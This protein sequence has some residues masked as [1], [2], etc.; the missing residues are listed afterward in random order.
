MTVTSIPFAIFTILTVIAYYAFPKKDHSWTVLL[1]AS[2]FFYAYNS[3]R[4]CAFILLSILS[5]Y[6][7]S[8]L[9]DNIGNETR[10]FLKSKKDEW[11][12]D[13][14]KAYKEKAEKKRRRIV[15][16]ALVLNFGILFILKYFNFFSGSIA[17]LL[18]ADASQAPRINLLL[19]LGISFYTFT[20]TGYLI[21]VYR[22][23]IKPE[24][25]L[26][27]FA[28]FVSFFP[29]IIQGPI[30][31]FE[32][33]HHQLIE[34]HAPQWINLKHGVM[35]IA[36]G[37]FKKMVIADT[38]WVAIKTYYANGGMAGNSDFAGYGGGIVL[39]IVLLYSIQLYADFSGGI[40]ISRG[41]CRLLG[42]DLEVNF[43]QPYFS[44]SISEYWRRWHITLGA[45]MKKYVFYP[46]AMSSL[47]TRISRGIA[48]SAFGKTA[49]G[50]HISKVFTTALAS[51]IVFLLVG[52]WHGANSKYIGFGVWNGAII[53]LSALLGPV[54][55]RS[56]SALHIKDSSPLWRLFQ[57]LRTFVVVAIGYIFDLADDFS[58]A[59][60]M[61]KSIV[62]DCSSAVFREQ[63]PTLGLNNVD[64]YLI[65][66]CTLIVLYMSIRF[67]MAAVDS[68]GELLE[69]RRGPVQ[70]IW[71]LGILLITL[72]F[73]MYGP[74]YDAAEFVYMQF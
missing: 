33:L 73:G 43:R 29:H 13:E 60:S 58:N 31:S 9:I 71:L 27:R 5:I 8:R 15:A 52:I 47:S 10:A 16:L 48:G 39:F 3:F 46:V 22:G 24:K 23:T 17:S 61:M 56:R 14:R 21:D 42:I 45:W 51:F 18:G 38:A 40:D 69:K 35:Q 30:S 62:F 68:P 25:N 2:S 54:Y 63:L 66:G 53:M 64:Y 49:A 1:I 7:A 6:A 26:F 12:R 67:E 55:E 19:P 72:I 74:A 11:S 37:F 41:I 34:G 70:W 59:I 65:A 50:K 57:M 32:H 28:L 4:Y 20:S 44:R 36:W